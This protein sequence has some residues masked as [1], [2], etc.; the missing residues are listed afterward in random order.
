MKTDLITKKNKRIAELEALVKANQD[1]G[2]TRYRYDIG[3]RC[4][5]CKTAK[6]L[7]MKEYYLKKG[8]K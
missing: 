2:H 7:S 6:S 5:L 3:C 1:A 8:K 4:D